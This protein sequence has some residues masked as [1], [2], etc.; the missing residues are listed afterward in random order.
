MRR[1]TVHQSEHAGAYRDGLYSA[2][3]ACIRAGDGQMANTLLRLLKGR[4]AGENDE[5][6]PDDA[7]GDTDGGVRM[8]R[9]GVRESRA[10]QEGREVGRVTR[11]GS[12]ATLDWLRDGCR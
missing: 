11:L 12:A 8:A 9:P 4:S 2:H 3:R 6:D 7:A 5:D 10:V 1:R